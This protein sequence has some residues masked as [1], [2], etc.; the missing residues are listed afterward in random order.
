MCTFHSLGA[1][2]RLPATS[3]CRSTC[4]MTTR[5]Q[6]RIEQLESDLQRAQVSHRTCAS[7]EEQANARVQVVTA[8]G[9]SMRPRPEAR[10][11][12]HTSSSMTD[13]NG[14][15]SQSKAGQTCL[16]DRKAVET[17]LCVSICSQLAQP[18]EDANDRA[19]PDT[20]PPSVRSS[21]AWSAPA[22]EAASNVLLGCVEP[23]KTD[24]LSALP[25]SCPVASS[26]PSRK[27]F[28]QSV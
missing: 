16:S 7:L 22:R 17:S 2:A 12:L 23:E 5:T 18:S 14:I 4:S 21:L 1:V 28:P 19:L 9:P 3:V 6:V 11:R 24:R 13:Y 15:P 27:S 8:T 10:P 20:K 26:L 25:C